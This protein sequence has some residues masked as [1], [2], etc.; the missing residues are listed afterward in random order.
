MQRQIHCK[1]P[2]VQHRR[3][4][5]GE[6]PFKCN[7][8]HKGFS[9]MVLLHIRKLTQ[10]WNDFS[11]IF[12]SGS[13]PW[14]NTWWYIVWPIQMLNPLHAVCAPRN[15]NAMLTSRT[16]SY[17]TRT[18]RGSSNAIYVMPPTWGKSILKPIYGLYT[19][20]GISLWSKRLYL[21]SMSEKV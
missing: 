15:L 6:K 7:L 3:T 18:S 9:Q 4:H 2:L 16:T 11:V 21:W 10:M 1:N 12:V 14:R 19:V 17:H 5:T 13:L 8:C 20:Y